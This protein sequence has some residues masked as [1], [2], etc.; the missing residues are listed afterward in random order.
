MTGWLPFHWHL[1][2]LAF[3]VVAGLAHHLVVC[4]QRLRRR[5]ELA[6]VMLV[7]VVV[8]PIGDLAASVSLTVATLQR[9]VIMLAVAPLLLRATP[10]SV[11]ESLTRPASVDRALRVLS[12]PG[13]ALAVVTA[14]GTTTLITPVVDWG[15]HSAVGR[16]AIV[17]ATLGAG[18]LL[19]LPVIHVVPGTRVLSPI[20]RAGYVFASSIVVTSLSIVWIFAR[21]SLYP[22]LH[23][24]SELHLSALLDQQLAG[25]VAKLGAYAPMW[26][27]AFVI[28][29]R[30]D[31]DVVPVEEA[32]LHWADVQRELLRVDR[33]RVRD[34]RRHKAS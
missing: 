1:G 13:M 5:A 15:A 27:I 22:A 32:P 2:E 24:Q 16:D 3:I 17:V 26:A 29:S 31:R 11:F 7:V 12:H 20:A 6:L 21:H 30:A 28:F 8:W 34:L 10:T 19:W 23:H 25:F 9:L 18:L 14:L 4:D 33:Q